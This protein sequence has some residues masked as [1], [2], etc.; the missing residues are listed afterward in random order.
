MDIKVILDDEIKE[1]LDKI[2]SSVLPHEN[3]NEESALT[4]IKELG[5]VIKLDEF[6]SELSV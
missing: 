3:Y 4:T 1:V 5:K 6:L 2:I